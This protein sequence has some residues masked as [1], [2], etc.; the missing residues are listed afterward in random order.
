MGKRGEEIKREERLR[1]GKRGE[2]IKREERLREGKK[3]E[4][5]MW[6]CCDES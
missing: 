1:E 6:L 2:E 4:E 5:C 3:G